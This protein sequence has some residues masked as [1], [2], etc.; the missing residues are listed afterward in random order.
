VHARARAPGAPAPSAHARA[1]ARVPAHVRAKAV[2]RSL[3][4]CSRQSSCGAGLWSLSSVRSACLPWSRGGLGSR[5]GKEAQ[6]SG[7]APSGRPYR[8]S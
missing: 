1:L 8:Q 7:G 3:S 6:A 4:S 2:R 5:V